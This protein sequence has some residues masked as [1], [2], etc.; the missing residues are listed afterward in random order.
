MQLVMR[1]CAALA[2]ALAVLMALT[3]AA[4]AQYRID[5]TQ[6][7]QAPTPIALVSFEGADPNSRQLGRDIV[8][9]INSDLE[10]S[11]LFRLID[12]AAFIERDVTVDVVPRHQDWRAVGA[13]ILVVGRVT[14]ISSDKA[15]IDI[16][17]WDSRA[18]QQ[19][20]GTSYNTS[21]ENYRRIGHRA[22]DAI[23][24][25]LTGENGYFDSRVVYIG[26]S[27]PKTSRTK[28]LC[29]MDQDGYNPTCLTPP[30]YQVLTQRFSPPPS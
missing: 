10:G 2:A 3:G 20:F 4:F 22:A 24:S 25:G 15:R 30:T 23:Y 5:I 6:G 28:R 8:S 18:G 9:V 29:I 13:D 16:R 11:G 21:P 7:N 14:L 27:G 12:E 19:I 17:A 26:E 1:T